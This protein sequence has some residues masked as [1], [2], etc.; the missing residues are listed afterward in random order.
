MLNVLEPRGEAAAIRDIVASDIRPNL[1]AIDRDG[2]YPETA[3]RR[4]GAAGAFSHHIGN[5]ASDGGLDRAIA[6]MAEVGETCLST[7]FCMWCQ[8]ALAW[9]LDRSDND[10]LKRRMLPAVASGTRLE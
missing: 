9:Y 7:A 6:A 10:S 1:H 3:M 4:L 8:D 5:S 2:V